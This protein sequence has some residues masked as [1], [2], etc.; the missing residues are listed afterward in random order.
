MSDS[1]NKKHLGYEVLALALFLGGA[2]LAVS[3]LMSLREGGGIPQ[4]PTTQT[5]TALLGFLGLVPFLGAAIGA[6]GLGAIMFLRPAVLPLR[7]PGGLVVA[8]TLA[9]AIFLGVLSDT[10]GGSLGAW[11][12]ANLGSITGILVGLVL[13]FAVALLGTWLAL[14][15][16]VLRKTQ[17]QGELN[18]VAAALREEEVDGVSNAEAQAL[19]PEDVPPPAVAPG[20]REHELRVRGELPEG[21]QPLAIAHETTDEQ[22]TPQ[23]LLHVAQHEVRAT[24][25][26]QPAKSASAD[27][28]AT[29]AADVDPSV[30]PI[31][32]V[33]DG[34]WVRESE[35][36]ELTSSPLAPSWETAA[37][38]EE[39][40]PPT[41][42]IAEDGERF[43]EFEVDVPLEPVA[44]T[45][46]SVPQFFDPDV[47]VEDTLE[48][49][50][51][52]ELEDDEEEE[53]ED[54]EAAELEDDEDEEDDEAAELEDDEEEEDEAAELED[55]EEEEDDEAAELEDDEDEEDEADEAAE[56]EDDEEEE[57]EDEEDDEAA[58]LED[59]DEEEE[60]EEEAAELALDEEKELAL[61]DLFEGDAA[62]AELDTEEE[63]EEE[64]E[65]STPLAAV[66]QPGLFDDQEE[67]TLPDVELTPKQSAPEPE[68]EP[69]PEPT[70]ELTREELVYR[71]G[72]VFLQ[73]GRV[74]V[75]ML[76][77]RFDLAFDQATDVLD[78]LQ[79]MGLIGPYVG[80]SRREILMTLDEWE[81][82][83]AAR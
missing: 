22:D 66:A 28:A 6:A 7:V 32:T 8:Y 37:L 5:V 69:E 1:K 13:S 30:K 15:M 75:S 44:E 43:D 51:A 59:D 60:Y 46:G 73:E 81:V 48:D 71:A 34:V 38:E 9:G 17:K 26:V 57:D 67:P 21:V 77:R 20:V 79:S 62:A 72:L 41:A 2:F 40:L 10:W 3:A 74:A 52:A 76:Q 50:E 42:A 24:A 56:L 4:N 39:A 82:S 65:V 36:A 16:P 31:P 68:P 12:P 45:A 14:G 83:A 63:V 11:L 33:E 47:V 53:D 49:E 25:L 61:E 58:E 29:P 23:E 19:F 18:S 54:D 80:G 27:L 70:V 78:E 64:V 55:D 35:E